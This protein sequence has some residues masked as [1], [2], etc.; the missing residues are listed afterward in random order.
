MMVFMN[1]LVSI[2]QGRGYFEESKQVTKNGVCHLNERR[3][4]EGERERNGKDKGCVWLLYDFA[5][6][7]IS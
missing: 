7:C 3:E 2:G 5:G 6:R 4:S 1:K